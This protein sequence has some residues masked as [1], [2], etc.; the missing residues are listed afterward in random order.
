MDERIEAMVISRAL[1]VPLGGDPAGGDGAAMTRQFD[2]A[3]LSAGFKLSGELAMA[4]TACEPGYV[5]DVALRVLPVVRRM[6]GDHVRHNVYFRDFP[7]N[8]PSTVEFWAECLHKALLAG[9]RVQGGY[10]VTTSE[11]NQSSQILPDPG[12]ADPGKVWG[13][14]NLL[15]L[16]DY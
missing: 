1:R 6:C 7:L 2:S 10:I 13:V 11:A 9:A 3:L 5:M 8:V 16:P 14:V 4:L 12:D 15:A